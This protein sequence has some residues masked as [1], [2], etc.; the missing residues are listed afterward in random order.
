[1][2]RKGKESEQENEMLLQLISYNI[3]ILTISK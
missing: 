2:K 3:N 1:M